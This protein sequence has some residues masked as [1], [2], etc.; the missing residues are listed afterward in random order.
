MKYIL[1][2]TL[3]WIIAIVTTLWFIDKENSFTYLGPVYW[4]CMVG[5]IVTMRRALTA[6]E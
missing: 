1:T 6:T 5:S 2:I 4:I 3:L